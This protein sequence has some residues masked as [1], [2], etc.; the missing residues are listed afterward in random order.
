MQ[1]VAM[2][3]PDVPQL[4]AVNWAVSGIRTEAT[5]PTTPSVAMEVQT[6]PLEIQVAWQEALSCILSKHIARALYSSV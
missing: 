6:I 1:T 3:T 4:L 5:R 2:H